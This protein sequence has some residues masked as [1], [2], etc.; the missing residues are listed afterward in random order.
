MSEPY[1]AR[2]LSEQLVA[3]LSPVLA[4][5][6]FQSGNALVWE[7]AP[8]E[9]VVTAAWKR[10]DEEL[11]AR[12]EFWGDRLLVSLKSRGHEQWSASAV[13]HFNE[14]IAAAESMIGE[15]LQK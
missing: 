10:A 6:G 7:G 9:T 4:P 8:Q 5:L 2:W 14:T 12:Y 13:V 11:T 3:R 1:P 15:K